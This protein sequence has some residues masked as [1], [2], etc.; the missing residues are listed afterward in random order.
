[1][2]GLSLFASRR[3]N[4]FLTICAVV[5][6]LVLLVTM[7]SQSV[8]AQNTFVITDGDQVIVHTTYAS[9]P[10]EALEEAG[11]DA[12]PD[13]YSATVSED[14]VYDITVNREEFLTV[15]NCG[16]PMLVMIEDETIGALLD[17]A[18][19]PT[20]EGYEISCDLNAAPIA[21]M[22][23]QVDHVVTNE[24]TYTVEIPFETT[25]VKDPYLPKGQKQVL[26]EGVV[27]QQLH[28]AKVTYHNAEEVARE[29]IHTE[30]I[31][32]TQNQ[33][34]AEGT[35]KKVG[36][37]P[38][39]PLIGDGVIVLTTGEVLTYYKKDT[40]EATAYTMYD[41]GCNDTTATMSKVRW[42]VVAV[43]P[44]VIPYG[45]RMFI[46]DKDGDFVYGIGT[47]EDCGGAIKGKR[48]DL[49]MPT[50]RQAYDYGRNDVTVYFLGDANK[51]ANVS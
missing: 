5:I 2:Q 14:G 37:R 17:R 6:P 31:R 32:E 48:L 3:R 16:E 29:V 21:D 8:F 19:I 23:I 9:D 36:K 45:T 22:T 4:I 44:K 38:D 35:G 40:Y 30:T 12:E 27:G 13:E 10:A 34:V 33:V 26:T 1:M 50:L 28:T 51:F 49:Y 18:G 42:G 15:M 25:K 20:G 7:L 43:D 11:V 41:E 46:I 39:E 47:A 24:E